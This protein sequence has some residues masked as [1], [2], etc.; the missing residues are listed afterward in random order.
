MDQVLVSVIMPAYNC[1]SYIGRSLDSALC[2]DVP[3]EVIVINDCSKDNLD[4]VMQPYVND[5][6][7]RYL[8]NERNMGVAE[9]RNRGVSLARGG[10]YCLSGC[11]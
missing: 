11:R 10:V 9:T 6:R 1:A 8:K 2:Q 7:V 5:S 3:L 4:R